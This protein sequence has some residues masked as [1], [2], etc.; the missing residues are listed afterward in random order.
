[1]PDFPESGVV[2]IPVSSTRRE[3]KTSPATCTCKEDEK[4]KEAALT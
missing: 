3:D 1:M 2:N 4:G